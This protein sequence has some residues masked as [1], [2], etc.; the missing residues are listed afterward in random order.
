M[1]KN[2][3]RECDFLM[4]QLRL[5]EENLAAYLAGIGLIPQGEPIRVERAGD[6]NINWVRRVQLR[7]GSSWVVK[8]ARPTLERFPEYRVPTERIVFESRYY[9]LAR[10]LEPGP[11]CCP[12]VIHF[13]ERE[14]V[15]V[16]EDLGK[17]ERLDAALARGAEVGSAFVALA[18]FLAAVHRGTAGTDLAGRFPNDAMR[19]LHGEHIFE[20]PLRENDFPLSPAL[21]ARSARLATDRGLVVLA[22]AAYRRYL[23]PRGA[24]VHGDAQAGNV[25]LADGGPRLLDAEIA[26]QGDPAFDLGTL[27]AHLLLWSVALGRPEKARRP[28]SDAWQAY[29]AL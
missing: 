1:S 22:D 24:L 20:L 19:R 17:A 14:R 16:L 26:H 8:Q 13:D 2:L 4:T 6:G 28:I 18:G 21:R 3:R 29:A 5:S 9:Q 25:L 27:F 11:S 23:E 12:G 10:P 7:S 15:L